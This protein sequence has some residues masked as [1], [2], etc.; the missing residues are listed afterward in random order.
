MSP[1]AGRPAELGL[2]CPLAAR[3]WVKL[4]ELV[5]EE[6]RQ[7]DRELIPAASLRECFQGSADNPAYGLAWWLNAPLPPGRRPVLRQ[8]TL[9]LDDLWADPWVPRDLV[10]AAGAAKQRLYVSRKEGWVAVRQAGGV[11]AAL[12]HGERSPFSD[13]EF[14]SRLLDAEVAPTTAAVPDGH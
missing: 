10:Y 4:G 2:G 12:A 13:R 7:S 3:E 9:G 11:H 5:R 6:G 14:L 8:A 1:G